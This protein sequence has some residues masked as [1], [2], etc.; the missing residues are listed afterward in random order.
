MKPE[1]AACVGLTRIGNSRWPWKQHRTE[2][3]TDMKSRPYPYYLRMVPN[4]WIWY[5]TGGAVL[6]FATPNSK[7]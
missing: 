1:W 7:M 3:W 2:V 4:K 6:C 5:N